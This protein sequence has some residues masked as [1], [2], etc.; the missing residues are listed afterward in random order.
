[1]SRGPRLKE[2]EAQRIKELKSNGL[3][4]ELIKERTGRSL[5]SIY[6]ALKEKQ[7]PT[8]ENQ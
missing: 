8:N 4:V 1:M 7:E 6:K 3:T 5:A 2:E